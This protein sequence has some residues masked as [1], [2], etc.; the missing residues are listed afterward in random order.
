[1]M[2]LPLNLDTNKRPLSTLKKHDLIFFNT[3]VIQLDY[4]MVYDIDRDDDIPALLIQLWKFR[5]GYDHAMYNIVENDFGLN[6]QVEIHLAKIFNAKISRILTF[7]SQDEKLSE[8]EKF[9]FDVYAEEKSE[10]KTDLFNLPYEVEVESENRT[11]SLIIPDWTPLQKLPVNR[12]KVDT[13]IEI[14]NIN[15]IYTVMKVLKL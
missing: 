1:M 3:D 5:G 15:D 6:K 13:L 11:L 8:K 10:Y 7:R 2:S 9:I 4:F 12:I 14:W